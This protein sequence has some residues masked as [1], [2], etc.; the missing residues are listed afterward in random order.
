MLKGITRPLSEK[1]VDGICSEE[2]PALPIGKQVRIFRRS[3]STF[4]HG[5]QTLHDGEDYK[6]AA[7]LDGV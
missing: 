6:V 4:V 3:S 7:N 2:I 1:L 5:E